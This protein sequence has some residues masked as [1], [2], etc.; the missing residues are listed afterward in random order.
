LAFYRQLQDRR[1]IASALRGLGFVHYF[2][3][4]SEGARPLLEEAL[5]LFRALDDVEGIA[6]TLDNLGYISSDPQEE[7]RLYQE[8]LA[9]RRRS[10]NLRGIGI[11]LGALAYRAIFRSDLAT[12]WRYTVERRQIEEELGN[13][14]GIANVFNRMGEIAFSEGDLA[15]AYSY[16]EQSMRLC[17]EI[18]EAVLLPSSMKGICLTMLKRGQVEGVAPLLEQAV[19]LFAKQG[20]GFTVSETLAVFA[21]LAV[22]QGEGQ[23][24]IILEA[25]ALAITASLAERLI[26]RERAVFEETQAAARAM[27]DEREVAEAWAAG[28]RMT[29]EQAVAYALA[30]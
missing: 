21:T 18:G 17:E 16:Y 2:Q 10:G 7:E 3:Q 8:S 11:S 20:S 9:L 4:D 19:A 22:A 25:A 6:A 27:L 26:P 29:L 30:R 12:A 13:Q 24:A 14:N 1:G 15:A 5:A 23:R 28:Q